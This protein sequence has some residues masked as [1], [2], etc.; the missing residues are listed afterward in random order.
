MA[1]QSGGIGNIITIGLL[2]GAAYLAWSWWQAQVMQ[3]QASAATA[4][5][6]VPATPPGVYTPPTAQEQMQAAAAANSIVTAQGGQADAYQW[7]T[8]WNSI[9]KPAIN[10]VNGIFFPN[11]LPANAAA[12][13]QAGGTPSQQGLPLM[14]LS[15]FL[16]ALQAH[17]LS[18][19]GQDGKMISVPVILAGKPTTMQLPWGTTP[20]MLQSMIRSRQA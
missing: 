19:L 18:G 20:A 2:G 4:Q 17:G 1:Q 12:V 13:T 9:G 14:T 5:P 10:N 16:A 6:V 3:A 15:T 11:G 8:L 7:A